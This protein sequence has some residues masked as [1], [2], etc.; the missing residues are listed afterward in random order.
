M[1][2]YVKKKSQMMQ[3]RILNIIIV[4]I[5]IDVGRYFFSLFSEDKIG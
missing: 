2:L 1:L 4:C 3:E 5:A